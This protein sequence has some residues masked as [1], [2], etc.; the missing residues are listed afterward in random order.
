MDAIDI[1][2]EDPR[3]KET[4]LQVQRIIELQHIANN[5]SDTFTNTKGVTKSSFPAR[6]AP[7]RIELP[8]KTIQLRGTK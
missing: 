3:N 2:K 4:E 8:N 1:L 7:E 5:L 6:N